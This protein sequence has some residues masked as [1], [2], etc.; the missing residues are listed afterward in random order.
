MICFNDIKA[1]MPV[2]EGKRFIPLNR[3]SLTMIAG[4][5]GVGKTFLSIRMAIEFLSENPTEKAVLFL[6]EDIPGTL[7]ARLNAIIAEF[8]NG[9]NSLV[10]RLFLETSSIQFV[11]KNNGRYEV[12][13]EFMKIRDEVSEYGFIV[14]DPL[15]AFYTGEE[16]SNSDARRFMQPIAEW[17]KDENKF[18][19]ILH[20]TNKE[21][22]ST[23][24]AGAFKDACRIVY[25]V[26]HIYTGDV[27][28]P[29]NREIAPVKDNLGVRSTMTR[30]SFKVIPDMQG[31]VKEDFDAIDDIVG[32]SF[33][34]DSKSMFTENYQPMSCKF[35]SLSNVVNADIA[36]CSHQFENLYKNNENA[37]IG[38]SNLIFLDFDDGLSLDQ[39]K[40]IFA[41]YRA[42]FY[43]TKSH[44]KLKGGTTCDRFRVILQ[45]D[46]MIELGADDYKLMMLEVARKYGADLQCCH[47]SAR[48]MGYSKS[49][50]SRSLGDRCIDWRQFYQVAKS[51][52]SLQNMIIERKV[53]DF[54]S[55]FDGDLQSFVNN[56]K[57]KFWEES[58]RNS[59]LSTIAYALVARAG[60][61]GNSLSDAL[62]N[63][64][65]DFAEPL[66]ESEVMSI[67]RY[68]N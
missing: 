48:F 29:F 63:I 24:G 56:L 23:R 5:G 14:F 49:E 25:E 33:S 22:G 13:E 53:K 68:K 54:P 39:A 31:C 35:N 18:I 16:N 32:Y 65:N 26:R 67:A 34:S 43:T 46:S 27:Q 36:L 21:G 41:E 55:E 11:T 38:T 57:S 42:I 64:N 37:I 30:S 10:D 6:T 17:C 1:S 3:G 28:D 62:L 7:K 61:T 40:K 45:A 2:F 51:K 15:L 47:I 8:F 9:D 44:G 66:S 60:L 50:V 4:E 59:T 52:K 19:S 20:H 58:Q 12:T